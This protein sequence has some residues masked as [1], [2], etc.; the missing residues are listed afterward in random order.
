MKKIILLL[1]LFAAFSCK[2][3]EPTQADYIQRA[4]KGDDYKI[5]LS[6]FRT[7]QD[8]L[9]KMKQRPI[10]TSAV[11][12]EYNNIIVNKT[13]QAKTMAKVVYEMNKMIKDSSFLK[14]VQVHLADT[15]KKA[16]LDSISKAKS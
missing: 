16:H 8:S 2:Q 12:F 15:L 10:D 9:D 1:L 6:N 3:K 11:I 7:V 14:N 4:I 13:V 5:V